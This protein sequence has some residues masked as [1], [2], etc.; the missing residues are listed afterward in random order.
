M[1][2]SYGLMN[3]YFAVVEFLK[4]HKIRLIILLAVFILACAFGI[5][6]GCIADAET[7]LKSRGAFAMLVSAEERSVVGHLFSNLFFLT[8]CFV[9]LAATALN[10]WVSLFGVLVFFYEV[11]TMGYAVSIYFVYFKLAALPYIIV[12][13]IPYC[14]IIGG[15]LAFMI[16][17]ATDC[18][19]EIRRCGFFDFEAFKNRLPHMAICGGIAIVGVLFEG[20]LGGLFTVGLII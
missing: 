14:F 19:L 7:V 5:R 20:L 13:Y 11:Y 12:C 4:N 15:A 6:G 10:F 17:I 3:C 16:V 1:R 18:G 2:V 9:V 8:V